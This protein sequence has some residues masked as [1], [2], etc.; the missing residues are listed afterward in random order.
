MPPL[1]D[2][3][4]AQVIADSVRQL[5]WDYAGIARNAKGLR[6]CLNELDKILVRLA[7]GMTE[8]LNMCQTARL[9][10][11]AALARRESR[12]GHFR[13]DYPKAKGAWRGKHLEW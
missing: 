10:A 9:I 7:P 2:R 4:A 5:M 8:E 11:T 6:K 13:S 3:G 1:A 12:G